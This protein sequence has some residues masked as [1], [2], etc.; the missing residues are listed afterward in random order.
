M[1]ITINSATLTSGQTKAPSR[2]VKLNVDLDDSYPTGGYDVSDQLEGGTVRY[3]ETVHADDGSALVFL[4]VSTAGMLMAYAPSA[5]GGVG[6]EKA[7]ESDLSAIAS[8]EINV[9]TE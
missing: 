6:A 7:N 5:N 8:V 2:W 1:A 3:S 4:K 9:Y